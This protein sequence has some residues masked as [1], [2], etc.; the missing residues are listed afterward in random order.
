MTSSFTGILSF[1]RQRGFWLR[2]FLGSVLVLAG[3][4][5]TCAAQV[6]LPGPIHL[7]HVNGY[8]MNTSGKPIA[9]ADVS[10][11]RDDKVAYRTRTDSF[12]GFKFE[13][14]SGHYSLQVARTE[15]SPVVRDIVVGDELVTRVEHKKLYVVAGPGACDYQCGTVYTS[16][17]DFD[18]AMKKLNRSR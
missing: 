15:S 11:M 9:N 8:L 13:H 14:V 17:H 18:Q 5:A 4:G 2:C 10:L 7:V 12:G 1:T 6:E 3:G 16:K